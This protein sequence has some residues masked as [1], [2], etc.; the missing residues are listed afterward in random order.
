VELRTNEC[1]FVK[2]NKSCEKKILS[3]TDV[4]FSA[5][6]FGIF[7]KILFTLE[8]K[9]CSPI[10]TKIQ[11]SEEVMG[12]IILSLSVFGGGGGGGGIKKRGGIW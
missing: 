9:C 2:K 3:R 1:P 4:A 7:R 12:M 5:F 8:V 10:Q 11:K 6:Y